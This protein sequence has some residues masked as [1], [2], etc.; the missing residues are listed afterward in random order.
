[1]VGH[2][3]QQQQNAIIIGGEGLSLLQPDPVVLE[4][5]RLQNLL[6]GSFLTH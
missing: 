6:K 5:N 1:M 3:Q 2:E 4:I